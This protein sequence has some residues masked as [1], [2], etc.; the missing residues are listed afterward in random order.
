LRLRVFALTCSLI[1][2]QL[3]G[4]FPARGQEDSATLDEL[5]RSAEQWAKENL[6]DDALRVLQQVD[7]DRVKQLLAEVQKQFHGEYVLDLASLKDAA[8]TA[9][10]LLE[11]YEET[12]PYA[13]WLKSHLD[14]LDVADQF[15]LIIPPPK[16]EPGRPP[17]PVPNPAPQL[18]REIWVKKLS[19]RPWPKTAKPYVSRLKP[20]FAIEKVPEQLVWIAEVESSFDPRARSPAGAAGLFQLMPATAKR[21]GLR[22]SPFDQRLKPEQSAQAAAKY[23]R[24]LH[25]HFKDWRL[26]LAAYNAGEGTVDRLLTRQK[27]RSFDAIATRLPAETQMFV[28]RVEAVLLRRENV[29]L[30]QL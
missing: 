25:G 14:Y 4:L 5:L 28:P 17:K 23:L 21:F 3:L 16:A 18:E 9:I 12:F 19:E 15:R 8:R 20:I 30:S 2:A 24:Y 1:A 6:D 22:V 10:P 29:K 7:R 11:Q 26:A 13:L 27:K